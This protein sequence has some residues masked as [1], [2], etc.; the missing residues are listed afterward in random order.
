MRNFSIRRFAVMLAGTVFLS[1]G[2]ALFKITLMGNDPS[3]AMM[4]AIGGVLN[5][6]FA[7][8]LLCMNCVF[9]VAEII[10][11]RK[12]IGAGTFVNWFVVGPAASAAIR[13]IESL[14]TVPDSLAVKLVILLAGILILSFGCALYQTSDLGIGPYDSLS[15]IINERTGIRYFRC[16]MLTDAISAAVAIALGGIIGLGT[17]ICAFGLGPFIDFFSVH[18]A[19][20]LCGDK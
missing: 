19:R 15:L 14:W 13:G 20:K 17:L 16:R 10:W 4:M 8:V 11:G 9:F 3:T 2:L 12:M 7:I 5:I 1:L 6:D 18:A